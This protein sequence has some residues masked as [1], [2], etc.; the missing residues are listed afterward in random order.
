MVETVEPLTLWGQELPFGW[1]KTSYLYTR[2]EPVRATAAQAKAAAEEAFA[3]FEE[4]ELSQITVLSMEET[5]EE[6]KDGVHF[7]RVYTCHEEITQKSAVG[8]TG[9]QN[10]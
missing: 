6:E 4:E 3:A 5:V 7:R 9:V 8:A 2:S 1:R 10:E